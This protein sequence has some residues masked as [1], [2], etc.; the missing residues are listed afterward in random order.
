MIPIVMQPE[1]ANF[2][3]S[4]RQPGNSFL[5]SCPSPKKKDWKRHMFWQKCQKDL[6]QAYRGI[7]AYTCEY[8]PQM[9]AKGSVD[10][11]LPKSIYPNLAYEWSNYRLTSQKVNSYKSDNIGLTDPFII[12]HGW[13]ILEFPD[14]MVRAGNGLSSTDIATV[15][16]TIDVLKL[17]K[18]DIYVQ[19]RCDVI[20]EYIK[21]DISFNF[22]LKY[23]PFIASEIDRQK[24]SACDLRT[25]FKI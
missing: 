20:L 4:I 21:G 25:L 13:F 14:C 17:N 23:R 7:C 16:R 8:M 1:P 3:N 22:L 9:T 5:T 10:H 19:S 18:D 11:F 24:L 15:E 12:K 6:Y 2:N